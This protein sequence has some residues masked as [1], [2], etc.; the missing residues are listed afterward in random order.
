MC[1]FCA[2][3]PMAASLGTAAQAKQREKRKQAELEGKPVPRAVI[4]AGTA[5][6]LLTAGLVMA[7]IIYHTTA[8]QPRIL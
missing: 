8:Y 6:I 2:M 4:P 1:M 3:V 7:S 5:T